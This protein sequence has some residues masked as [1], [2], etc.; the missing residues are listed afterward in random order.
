MVFRATS[1]IKQIRSGN[2][3]IVRAFTRHTVAVT[4]KERILRP[5][6]RRA[7]NPEHPF[8]L[9]TPRPVAIQRQ[10]LPS[11]IDDVALAT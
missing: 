5:P 2:H 3:L 9:V 7:D 1:F 4:D 8:A 10:F 11:M 6:T